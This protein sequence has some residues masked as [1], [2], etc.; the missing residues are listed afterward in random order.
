ML[1]N[2]LQFLIFF[3]A[4]VLLY[5]L[6]PGRIRNWMLLIASYYFYMCW[7]PV[8]ALLILFS[9]VTTWAGARIIG[10]SSRTSKR[11]AVLTGVLTVNFAIL[12]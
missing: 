12:F 7:Q 2:S 3:P 11:K 4:V 9:T 1:F 10:S 8:Y 6:L 5:W